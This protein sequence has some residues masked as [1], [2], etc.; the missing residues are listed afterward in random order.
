MSTIF[1]L[2]QKQNL[3]AIGAFNE[4]IN[5]GVISGPKALTTSGQGVWDQIDAGLDEK[6]TDL[7]VMRIMSTY[8][9]TQ[10]I[11]A[12]IEFFVNIVHSIIQMRDDP[13]IF[14]KFRKEMGE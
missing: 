5:Q 11:E 1:T 6:P 8:F 4:L 2:E 14:E 7:H 12:D 3:W 9:R 13:E 10:E